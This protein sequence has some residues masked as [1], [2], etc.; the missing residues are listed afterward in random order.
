MGHV[1]VHPAGGGF[2]VDDVQ[3]EVDAV[4]LRDVDDR[5]EGDAEVESY[6]VAHDRDGAPARAIVSLLTPTRA[7]RV[8]ATD[9]AGLAAAIEDADP[10]GRRV[11]VRGASLTLP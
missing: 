6:T 10:L 2:R 4:P 7:R 3:A 5:Y 11:T 1:L 9:D 8:L